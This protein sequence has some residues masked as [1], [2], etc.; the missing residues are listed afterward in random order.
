MLI[1]R[2]QRVGRK[3]EP[4]F[5]IVLTDSKNGTKSGKFLE[6]LGSYDA[7]NKNKTDVDAE[8]VKYWISKGVQLSGTIHNFLIDRKIIDGKKINVLSK[9]TPIKKETDEQL[10]EK[11]PEDKKEDKVEEKKEEAK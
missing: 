11:K 1:I 9:K 6:I 3:N 5:R 4:T 7:R 8:R 2:L 10:A